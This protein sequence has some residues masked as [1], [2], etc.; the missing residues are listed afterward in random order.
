VTHV[1][2]FLVVAGALVVLGVVRLVLTTD[3]VRQILAL[4]VASAGVLLVLVTV[5]ARSDPDQPDPVPHALVL[6]GIVVT[7]SV[8]AVALGLARRV[9]AARDDDS[10]D[11]D[12][13]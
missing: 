6:T 4:N 11:R 9:E 10:T 3:L 12:D 1:D 7:V 13:P 8:T 2:L 5:A